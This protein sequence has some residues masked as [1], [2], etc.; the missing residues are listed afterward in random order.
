M[1]SFEQLNSQKLTLENT[2][3]PAMLHSLHILQ[4]PSLELA[5]EI[6]RELESNPVLEVESPAEELLPG[7]LPELDALRERSEPGSSGDDDADVFE[8]MYSGNED[9]FQEDFSRFEPPPESPPGAPAG[10]NP[11]LDELREFRLN[12]Y[13]EGESL[14]E[15]L[16]SELA[17]SDCPATLRDTAA[18]IIESIDD[19]GYLRTALPDIAQARETTMETAEAAL[20]VVQSLGPAG[21]GARTPEE[22]LLLQLR[23][24]GQDTVLRTRMLGEVF[25]EIA[26]NHLPA[27][28]AKLGVS[29]EELRKN[30]EVIRSLDPHPGAVFS[31]RAAVCVQPDIEIVRE[32]GAW[33]IK[34]EDKFIPRLRVSPYY[35]KMLERN[36]LSREEREYLKTRIDRANE[37]M[38]SI[39]FRKSTLRMIAETLLESQR[40]FWDFGVEKL[41]PLTMREV[42]ARI[43]RDEATVSR[44]VAN[45]YLLCRHGFFELRYFFTAGYVSGDGETF[46][47]RAVCERI[48]KIIDGE[49]PRKPLSDQA[50]S[51]MLSAEKIPVA[52]RTVAKYRESMEIPVA[53]KRKVF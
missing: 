15:H 25:D 21:V 50:I 32:N 27:A 52:R 44:A 36:D 19:N 47:A 17:C 9:E 2:I 7:N 43:G 28:A 42:S 3:A 40:E 39:A 31:R 4:L 30:L 13:S 29:M 34:M 20:E 10:T 5:G 6:N 33:V 48:K 16:F 12:S 45:K 38:H 18:A 49:D 26:S 41:R 22:C 8:T 35:R 24:R 11:E 14:H 51:D 46:S 37:L 1:P 23:A 53:G